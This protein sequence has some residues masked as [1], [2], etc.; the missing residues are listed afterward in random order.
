MSGPGN[1]IAAGTAERRGPEGLASVPDRPHPPAPTALSAAGRRPRLAAIAAAASRRTGAGDNGAE[2]ISGVAGNAAPHALACETAG[3]VGQLQQRPV[4]RA[5][6]AHRRRHVAAAHR[7]PGRHA[8]P[9][10]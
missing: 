6:I 4:K 8:A 7:E 9:G 2:Y 10:A 3:P 1:G 5:H